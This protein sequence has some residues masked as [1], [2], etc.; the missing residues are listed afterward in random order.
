MSQRMR[1]D[2]LVRGKVVSRGHRQWDMELKMEEGRSAPREYTGRILWYAPLKRWEAPTED[3][4]EHIERQEGNLIRSFFVPRVNHDQPTDMIRL[5]REAP[6]YRGKRNPKW[7]QPYG[8]TREGLEY[9]HSV[10][11]KH[12]PGLLDVARAMAARE[13]EGPPPEQQKEPEPHGP[14]RDERPEEPEQMAE[15]EAI[16]PQPKPEEIR[17]GPPPNSLV[18]TNFDVGG[19]S[20]KGVLTDFEAEAF[21]WTQAQMAEAFGLSQQTISDHVKDLFA[22]GELARDDRTYRFYRL[23]RM[24]G[25][26]EVGRPIDHYSLDVFIRVGFKANVT[27]R[28]K[29]FRDKASEIIQNHIHGRATAPQADNSLTVMQFM[30][31]I[32]DR[33]DRRDDRLMDLLSKLSIGPAVAAPSE[34]ETSQGWEAGNE[35]F[36]DF[37]RHVPGLTIERFREERSAE[38]ALVQNLDGPWVCT[39]KALAANP[40]LLTDRVE[41]RYAHNRRTVHKYAVLTSKGV[42]YYSE[43]YSKS[44]LI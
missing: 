33:M 1:L 2:S 26:R 27:E 28:T 22:S 3:V 31:N 36:S 35:S 10:Q 16:P 37:C 13:A 25:A 12:S 23:V 15:G 29:A 21:W 7:V 19:R 20:I 5:W 9:L 38:G 39:P 34:P 11:R 6:E 24:E 4:A 18:P 42:R 30:G 32:M 43:W 17:A 8:I 14:S 41:V 44:R 40:K